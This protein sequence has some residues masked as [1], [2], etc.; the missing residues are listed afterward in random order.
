MIAY[1]FPGQGVS[2]LAEKI[3]R[4]HNHPFIAAA[5]RIIGQS[6]IRDCLEGPAD[7]FEDTCLAQIGIFLLG[8]IDY[9]RRI[10]KGQIPDAVAGHS[11]GE[12]T[13]LTAS[14]ALDF[15]EALRL[16]DERGELMR[17]ASQKRKGAMACILGM[18][19]DQVESVLLDIP[20]VWIAAINCPG[21]ITISGHLEDVEQAAEKCL[22]KGAKK[23]VKLETS[24]AF[25]SPL[26]EHA[27]LDFGLTLQL[28]NIKIPRMA[29]FSTVSG[30]QEEGPE[31]IRRLLSRQMISTVLFEQA[32]RS[33]TAY[34]ISSFV[35]LEPTGP[36]KSIIRRI[37]PAKPHSRVVK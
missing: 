20:G 17:K 33:M 3:E 22:N 23:V 25:H 1:I 19:E 4:E 15:A 2:E 34:G 16:V 6:T 7:R 5:G 8:L 26:M 12:F 27:N 37:V 36:L 14:G 31:T 30:N 29:F 35:E 18:A 9:S 13:A 11:L 28:V 32:I 21:N 10:S 24:A